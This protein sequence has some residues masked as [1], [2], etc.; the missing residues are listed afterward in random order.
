[1]EVDLQDL[2]EN[3]ENIKN[4]VGIIIFLHRNF[5]FLTFSLTLPE[6]VGFWEEPEIRSVHK[7]FR[8]IQIG[9]RRIDRHVQELIV[10]T[11]TMEMNKIISFLRIDGDVG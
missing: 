7:D 10:L 1:M 2:F 4:R 8:V 5:L 9:E 11:G 6:I 3:I